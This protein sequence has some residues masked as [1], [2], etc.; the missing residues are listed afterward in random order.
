MIRN[1]GISLV[2]P[3]YNEEASI[4]ETVQKCL[5]ILSAIT[6]QYEVIIIN[7]GSMDE[8]G[9]IADQL[10]TEYSSVRVIHNPINL[11]IGISL[12]IGFHAAKYEL[13][14]NNSMDYP[15][16][17]KDLKEILPFFPEVDVVIIA[18][19]DRS[20]H[21]WYRKMISIV[22]NWIIRLLFFINISDFNFIQVYKKEVLN[23]IHVEAQS[24][25]FV[26]AELLI[27]ARDKKFKI[28]EVK[29]VFYPREKGES[30]CGKP[31]HIFWAFADMLS[32]WLKRTFGIG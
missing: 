18:R 10:Q 24:P 31:R 27:K 5:A 28:K 25:S 7:D 9:K 29:K 22:H 17:L 19:V 8:M 32:F 12:L 1:S 13:V 11:G 3:G 21:S 2:I 14:L 4:K 26:T 15:F 23:A 30:H 20:A 6:E 16:D